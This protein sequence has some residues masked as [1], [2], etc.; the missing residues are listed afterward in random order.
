MGRPPE[1]PPGDPD[2]FTPIRPNPYI[3]GNP[4]R[5]R[6]MFFGRAAEFDLVRKRFADSDRGGLLVFCGER[7]SGKTSILFQI[8]DRRLGPDFIPVLIDMQSMAVSDEADFLGKI[9]ALILHGIGPAA[10][11]PLPDFAATSSSSAAFQKF[12]AHVMRAHPDRKL[13]LLFDEYELFENKIDAGILS[14]DT[15]HVLATLIENQ[16]V[17]MIF[18]GSQHLEARRRDYWNILGKSIYKRISY[19][20]RQDA[21]DLIREPVRGIVEYAPE[22]VDAIYRL[23]AGQPFYTQAV[24][25]NLIDWLNENATRE[26]TRAAVDA[27][28]DGLV[29]NPLPQMIFL[30][31][32]LARDEKLVLAL[33]AETLQDEAGFATQKELMRTISRRDYP[34]DLDA[35]RI[36]PALEKLFKEDELLLKDGAALPGYAFRMDLWRRWIRRMHSVWQVMREEGFAI[37]ARRRRLPWIVAAAAAVVVVPAVLYLLSGRGGP[38]GL[39]RL[40]VPRPAGEL[41]VRMQATRPDAVLRVDGQQVGVGS[42]QGALPI[43]DHYVQMTAPGYADTNFVLS[44]RPGAIVEPVVV[45]R[46]VAAAAGTLDI[47]TDPPGARILVD[48]E[49]RG[50]SPLTLAVPAGEHQVT[51][52]LPG[53]DTQAE[54]VQVEAAGTQRIRLAFG[55]AAL[56]VLVTTEPGSALIWVDQRRLGAAPVTATGLTP[57]THAFRA[58][59]AGHV[60]RDSA[61]AVTAEL[62]QLHLQLEREPPGELEVR[63]DLA[64]RL[65][66]DGDPVGSTHL[67]NWKVPLAA[68]THVIQVVPSGGDTLAATVQ[69][70]AGDRITYEYSKTGMHRA[71]DSGGTP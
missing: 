9:A 4:V 38:P 11:V 3:V 43:G 23:T 2:G 53:R 31:D 46:A 57:G 55:T 17:F 61:V 29:E 18:T 36:A 65:I 16:S 49:P 34:L 40:P 15:L 58:E 37:R 7:R 33:L 14:R 56:S 50:T 10:G 47:A 6:N 67:Y 22:A 20:E 30:W 24:C 19:L 68:G 41:P 66:V 32:T 70:R 69:I 28:A 1:P 13:I 8:V 39:P 64:A 12:V 44:V 25:Q 26:A 5:G 60:G 45:L 35:A 27:V 51:A 52:T 21:L 63:G 48:G 62:R 42:W 71:T 59:L 54:R